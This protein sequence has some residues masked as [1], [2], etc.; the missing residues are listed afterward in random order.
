MIHPVSK[1]FFC[2]MTS[3]K[4]SVKEQRSQYFGKKTITEIR[5]IIF[6]IFLTEADKSI[7][8]FFKEWIM[9]VF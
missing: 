8:T 6:L 7:K 2:L 3:A 4:V 5:L 1:Y 9:K